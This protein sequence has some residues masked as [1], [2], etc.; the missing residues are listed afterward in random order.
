VPQDNSFE[1]SGASGHIKPGPAP[2]DAS[3][4]EGGLESESIWVDETKHS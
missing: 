2:A 4:G 3:M 1:V